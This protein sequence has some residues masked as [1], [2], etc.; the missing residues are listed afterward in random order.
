[1][2]RLIYDVG[3]GGTDCR[4]NNGYHHARVQGGGPAQAT[5]RDKETAHT[6]NGTTNQ[7]E[8]YFNILAFHVNS[9]TATGAFYCYTA[10]LLKLVA[11]YEWTA[12]YYYHTI[13]FNR[14]RVEMAAGDYS[15]WDN[16][17]MMS[18]SMVH[19]YWKVTPSK[20]GKASIAS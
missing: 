19:R 16:V 12:I 20:Q 11:E 18:W 10:H 15:Q 2:K 7:F 1:M 4:C 5:N 13:F 14:R 3:V 6:F 8:T 17:T 9:A